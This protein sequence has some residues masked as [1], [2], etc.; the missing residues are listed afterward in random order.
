MITVVHSPSLFAVV[1]AF[2]G[3]QCSVTRSTIRLK[4]DEYRCRSLSRMLSLPSST[5]GDEEWGDR[6]SDRAWRSSLRGW[7]VDRD[8]RLSCWRRCHRWTWRRPS[9]RRGSRRRGSCLARLARLARWAALAWVGPAACSVGSVPW[10]RARRRSRPPHTLGVWGH[11]TVGLIVVDEPGD[12]RLDQVELDD[13]LFF[14][15]QR[16]GLERA[17]E[18]GAGAVESETV[19]QQRG[20]QQTTAGLPRQT[21]ASPSDAERP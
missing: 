6:R 19:E 8:G 14:F 4:N 7:R 18:R 9:R 13:L 15:G 17:R 20:D 10:S 2:S 11:G 5:S 21:V 12:L 16:L 1:Y 3:R